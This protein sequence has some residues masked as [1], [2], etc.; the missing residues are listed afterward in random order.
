MTIADC[1]VQIT[2]QSC[3]IHILYRVCCFHPN[4]YCNTLTYLGC[5]NAKKLVSNIQYYYYYNLFYN[6]R[7]VTP[8]S[9]VVFEPWSHN[10][11]HYKMQLQ[12][13]VLPNIWH[14]FCLASWL[15]INNSEKSVVCILH[16]LIHTNTCL[17][18]DY[19]NENL[20][21]NNYWQLFRI[22]N[23]SQTEAIHFLGWCWVAKHGMIDNSTYKI[24][25]W[26]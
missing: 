16:T 5:A 24:W 6:Y 2:D 1:S 22:V 17:Y 3:F 15:G 25:H 19:S 21:L 4:I 26:S 13:K 9:Y 12:S 20:N 14:L 10:H 18:S 11:L 23:F 8:M 7:F